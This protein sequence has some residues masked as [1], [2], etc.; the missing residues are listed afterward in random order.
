MSEITQPATG[1]R[2]IVTTDLRDGVGTLTLHRPDC[3]NAVDAVSVEALHT[4]LN[5]LIEDPTCRVIV[6]RG[7][8]EV[9]CSGWDTRQFDV[10]RDL[11]GRALE[12]VFERARELLD[13]LRDAPQ[14]T[15]GAVQGAALGFGLSLTAACDLA[16]AARDAR[17]GLPEVRSGVVPAFVML[18]IARVLPSKQALDWLLTGELFDG[19]EALRGGLVSRLVDGDP[20][21]EA[22]RIARDLA[23]R[24][25]EQVSETKRCFTATRRGI[26]HAAIEE[27][28]RLSAR[29]ITGADE[30]P[31]GR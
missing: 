19:E 8:G 23:A 7:Q 18:D 28:I 24:P 16:V 10:L 2:P 1:R 6:V 3:R 4:C 21:A 22:D 17:F 26:T 30:L 14:V 13:A 15:I 12:Q 9:F 27:A 29:M 20:A 5:E 31:P 11:P 25:A